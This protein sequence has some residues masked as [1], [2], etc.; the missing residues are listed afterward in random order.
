MTYKFIYDNK[1]MF[2]LIFEEQLKSFSFKFFDKELT[3]LLL[4][5]IIMFYFIFESIIINELEF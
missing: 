1:L 3:K 5:I 2:N 4:K